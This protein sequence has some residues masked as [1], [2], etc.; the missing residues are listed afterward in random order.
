MLYNPHDILLR[1]KYEEEAEL[2]QA[3]EFQERRMK[4]LQLSDLKNNPIHH[5]RSFSVGAPFALPHPLSSHVISAG[6]SSDIGD[7][8][9]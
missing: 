9:G 2:Q 3:L 4:S 5:Q 7:I 1:R 8:T 6:L